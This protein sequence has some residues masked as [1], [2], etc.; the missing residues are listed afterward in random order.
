[1]PL[2]LVLVLDPA[3]G[4]RDPFE[5]LV[6]SGLLEARDDDVGQRDLQEVLLI[7]ARPARR[8]DAWKESGIARSSL[9]P[10][11]VAQAAAMRLDSTV[12]DTG[13]TR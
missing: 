13:L 11:G 8:Q 9:P 4:Q 2:A 7:A 6:L 10:A 3:E 1:V 12:C 5:D